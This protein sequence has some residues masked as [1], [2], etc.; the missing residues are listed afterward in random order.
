MDPMF[1][2]DFSSSQSCSAS[3]A[4]LT[5]GFA[6]IAD[7]ATEF[8][9]GVGWDVVLLAIGF[10]AAIGIFCGPF[11][12]RKAAQLDPIEALRYE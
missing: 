10:S 12:A 1:C 7:W 3:W 2:C 8:T 9:V 4:G 11:P 5:F 6:A